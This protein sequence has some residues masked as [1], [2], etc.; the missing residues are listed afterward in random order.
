MSIINHSV[1]FRLQ[2]TGQDQFVIRRTNSIQ[3][4]YFQIYPL[5]DA[6]GFGCVPE[7]FTRSSE[8][9]SMNGFFCLADRKTSPKRLLYLNSKL[10][11]Q[12]DPLCLLLNSLVQKRLGSRKFLFVCIISTILGHYDYEFKTLQD[13][14]T[15]AIIGRNDTVRVDEPVVKN[16]V[17][18]VEEQGNFTESIR[19]TKQ[20]TVT[21]WINPVFK[22][23]PRK[24]RLQPVSVLTDEV[25][26]QK[27][28]ISLF[29][30]IG[31]VE[32]KF[33]ACSFHK[34]VIVLDVRMNSLIT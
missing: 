28:D 12:K 4:A 9:I 3:D 33:I 27:S 2:I 11:D 14:M 1:E 16:G 10:M 5:S 18:H 22:P 8:G 7:K 13:F 29:T 32:K 23:A 17:N 6:I 25:R 19:N 30:L 26:I 20:K 24:S 31:Q 21:R 15:L 34:Y